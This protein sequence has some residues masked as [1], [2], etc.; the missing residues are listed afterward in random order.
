MNIDWGSFALGV[1]SGIW[2]AYFT[3]KAYINKWGKYRHE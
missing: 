1:G 2:L 3:V